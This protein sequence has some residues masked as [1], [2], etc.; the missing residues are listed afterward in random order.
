MKHHPLRA[1]ASCLIFTS[2]VGREALTAESA[3]SPATRFSVPGSKA[4]REPGLNLGL[5]TRLL[6][7]G[8]EKLHKSQSLQTGSLTD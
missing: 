2:H 8:P 7:E 4:Q 3:A 1:S 6:S 5:E